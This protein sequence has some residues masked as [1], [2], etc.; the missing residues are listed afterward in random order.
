M[1][2]GWAACVQARNANGWGALSA[3]SELDAA[4]LAPHRPPAVALAVALFALLAILLGVAA[5]VFYGN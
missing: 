3:P 1:G 4:A 2:A 5:T